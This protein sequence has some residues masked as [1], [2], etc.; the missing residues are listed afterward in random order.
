MLHTPFSAIVEALRAVVPQTMAERGQHSEQLWDALW[1]C[2]G[3][4]TYPT[5]G[6]YKP[7]PPFGTHLGALET[8]AADLISH[9]LT[10][11]AE[12]RRLSRSW[13]EE[14]AAGVSRA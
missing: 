11:S 12:F 9:C 13:V 1:A 14:T 7:I 10:L 8:P 6:I 3:H 4:C 2:M 5:C